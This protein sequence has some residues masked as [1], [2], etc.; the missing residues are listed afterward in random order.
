M[1]CGCAVEPDAPPNTC[2]CPVCLG[3]PGSLPV[4][5]RRAFEYA[6]LTGLALNCEIARR[7]KWDR[8]SYYYPDLPKN[9]QISQYDLPIAQNGYVEFEV[10]GVPRK[11]RI[12]RAHLEEDAGKNVHDVPGCTL[13]DLNRAGTPLLEIVTEP[14][15]ET[16][17]EAHAFCTE[18]QRIV[19]Y[20]G[21]SEANMQKGQM[22]FEPNVNLSINSDGKEFRTP[23][24]EIK[25]LNSFRAVRNAIEYESQRQEAAWLAD[26]AYVQGNVPNENRG[27]DDEK[28]VTEFQRL[29]EAAHDYRYFPDPD[30]VPVELADAVIAERRD[31][32]P[33][34]PA[35]CRRRFVS[36]YG[37][38][39]KDAEIIINHRETAMLFEAVVNCGGPPEIAGK[40][41]IN[42][43]LML[44][45]DRNVE[46][47]ELGVEADRMA[48]LAK[49]TAAGT[50][51]K[52]AAKSLAEV[53]VE[54]Q[55][56]PSVLAEE[57]GLVQ[58]QD[59]GATEAWV[60]QAIS[61]NEQAVR[62]ALGNPKKAKAA[63]G[64]LR[65][66]IMKISGG[67]A[68]PK[69]VGQLIEQKLEQLR[70]DT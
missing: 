69:L 36:D 53:M 49:I 67:K 58:V 6:L 12:K 47:T 20:L 24:S 30:L 34:L 25:N 45:N 44:A 63:A 32:L 26:P 35:S 8:K 29:K 38:D 13:V 11:I 57:L 15:I 70:S 41:F 60:S 52:T 19:R 48:R 56:D 68:D 61:E 50:V 66:Q 3:H 21:V 1:F 16:A 64:F 42:V 22:R 23:L 17:D 51:N 2:V 7:T 5:N 54:R 28:G 9:Y 14:D 27:W 39:A 59:R 33:E 65:G 46:V 4:I 43:W 31:S 18:L 37:L 40:Q 62:D 55:E 10:S